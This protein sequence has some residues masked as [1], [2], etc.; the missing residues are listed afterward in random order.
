MCYPDT[1]YFAVHVNKSVVLLFIFD[2]FE[3]VSNFTADT[4]PEREKRMGGRGG[5][6]PKNTRGGGVEE[7]GELGR[8][9]WEGEERGRSD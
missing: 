4:H 5:L 7:G 3:L 2:C 9:E 6:G 8:G 1:T